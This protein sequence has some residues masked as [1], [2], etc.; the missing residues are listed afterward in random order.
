MSRCGVDFKTWKLLGT[1]NVLGRNMG[2]NGRHSLTL[3]LIRKE[4]VLMKFNLSYALRKDYNH[5]HEV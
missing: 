4:S 3:S 1:S 5:G 2:N